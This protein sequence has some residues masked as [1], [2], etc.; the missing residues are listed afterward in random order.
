MNIYHMHHIIPKH[1]GGTDDQENLIRLSIEDHAEAHRILYEQHHN[2]YD[3][4]AW[5]ALSGMITRQEAI[6]LTLQESG[7]KS[8]HKTPNLPSIAGKALWSKP[9]MREHLSLKRKEQSAEGKNPMQGK[10]H[11]RTNCP[12]C[13]KDLPV[14]GLKTHLKYCK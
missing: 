6:M 7:R 5:L 10:K 9:G 14:N 8:Y 2:E 4:V 1:M 3:R 11:K 12:K 13:D